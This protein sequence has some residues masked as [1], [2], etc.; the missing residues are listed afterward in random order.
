MTKN[1]HPLDKSLIKL[2][3]NRGQTKREAEEYIKKHVYKLGSDEVAKIKN[4]NAHF[5]L[6]AKEKLIE[7][8]L[9]LRRESLIK[10]LESC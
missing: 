6:H 4:Y 7:E 10:R 9:E 1:I 2:L 8:I 5:G 3:Q